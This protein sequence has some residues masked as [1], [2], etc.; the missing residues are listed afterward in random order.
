MRVAIKVVLTVAVI[1]ACSQIAKRFPS[2]AGLIAVMPLTGLLV[3]LWVVSDNPGNFDKMVD[4]TRSAL[5]GIGPAILFYV[6]ALI[7]FRKR[8]P[9]G[10][11]LGISF[12]V[13][14]VGAA[15]HQWLLAWRA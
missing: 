2:L 14:L 4:Y 15:V 9:L 7:C 11:V 12:G 1:I 5:W 3:L 8:L 10:A 13:W 6:A